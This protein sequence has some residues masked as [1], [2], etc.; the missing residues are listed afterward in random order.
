MNENV[1]KLILVTLWGRVEEGRRFSNE[2]KDQ[3]TLKE[4][5]EEPYKNEN[6]M[7]DSVEWQG[8]LINKLFH[9]QPQKSL[10]IKTSNIPLN[11]SN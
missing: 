1:T 9:Y 4:L 6:L 2:G 5:N 8:W 3:T 7:Y 10:Q 11:H